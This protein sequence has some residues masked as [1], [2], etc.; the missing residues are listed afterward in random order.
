[1][2]SF[3]YKAGANDCDRCNNLV[4]EQEIKERVSSC[5]RILSQITLGTHRVKI[6][7]EKLRNRH[8]VEL[9][10]AFLSNY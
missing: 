4:A 7:S 1:M 8:F 5:V 2:L 9:S 10:K 6:E 3:G